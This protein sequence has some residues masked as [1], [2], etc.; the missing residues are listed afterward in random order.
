M[1]RSTFREVGPH[2][3]DQVDK[4]RFGFESVVE[5]KGQTTFFND[6]SAG[7]DIAFEGSPD[8]EDRTVVGHELLEA[9]RRDAPEA[10]AKSVAIVRLEEPSIRVRRIDEPTNRLDVG[11]SLPA[12]S[13]VRDRHG[14]PHDLDPIDAR[15]AEVLH[16]SVATVN[17]RVRKAYVQ[18]FISTARVDMRRERHRDARATELGIHPIVM[19]IDAIGVDAIQ[20]DRS[21]FVR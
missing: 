21:Q 7:T 1:C 9:V 16:S 15:H 13:T 18:V 19:L 3:I 8:A 10:G 12:A 20:R 5:R 17:E 6:I 2:G 14:K 4:I 11:R